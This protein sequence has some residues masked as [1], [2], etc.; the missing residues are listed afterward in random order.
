[1]ECCGTAIDHLRGVTNRG[2]P[3][4]RWGVFRCFT[5]DYD[6]EIVDNGTTPPADRIESIL[7]E[8]RVLTRRL[9]S[10]IRARFLPASL[11]AAVV[12]AVDSV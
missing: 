8:Y 11:R 3:P 9:G 5:G 10:S 4:T 12:R 7:T 2:A 1:M 6:G